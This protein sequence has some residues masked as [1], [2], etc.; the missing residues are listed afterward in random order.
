MGIERQ[1]HGANLS[2][3][4]PP[5]EVGLQDGAPSFDLDGNPGTVPANLHADLEVALDKEPAPVLKLFSYGTLRQR[6]VLLIAI[7]I[8]LSML[9]NFAPASVFEAISPSIRIIA[10]DGMVVGTLAAVLLNLAL[11]SEARS[12]RAP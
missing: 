4:V 3:L 2:Q 5:G 8:G 1:G 10:T 12:A 9:T 6:D 11:P 7:S